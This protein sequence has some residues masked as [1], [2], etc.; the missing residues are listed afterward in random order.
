M[1]RRCG[2]HYLSNSKVNLSIYLDEYYD[3]DS[4][5][6]WVDDKIVF[7]EKGVTTDFSTSLAAQF[8]T[9]V[10]EKKIKILCEVPTRNLSASKTLNVKGEVHLRVSILNGILR[11]IEEKAPPVFF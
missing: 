6:I 10:E 4:V 11:I 9:S 3:N 1:K 2:V 8:T 5:M 7:Q